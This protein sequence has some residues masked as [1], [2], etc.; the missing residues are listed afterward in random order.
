MSIQT[1]QNLQT[2]IEVLFVVSLYE[3]GWLIGRW[4][5][6]SKITHKQD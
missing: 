3:I 5:W 2:L 1:L 4:L 6:P